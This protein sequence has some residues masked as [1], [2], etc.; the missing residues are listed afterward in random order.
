M[1]PHRATNILVLGIISL[2]MCM[3]LGI[4][5]W[6]MGAKDLKEMDAG[7]MDPDGRGMTQAGQICGIVA[8]CMIIAGIICVAVLHMLGYSL[9]EIKHMTGN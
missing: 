7:T 1:K 5:P 8:T 9:E 6:V 2:V 4:V 3:P